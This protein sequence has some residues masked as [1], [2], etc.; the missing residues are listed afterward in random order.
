MAAMHPLVAVLRDA[1]ADQPLRRLPSGIASIARRHR[2]AGTLYHIDRTRGDLLREN[3]REAC[4]AA[5]ADAVG[6]HLLRMEVLC[7]IWPADL[8][9]PLVFKG[10][11]LAENVYADPGARA[12]RDLDLI[13]PPGVFEKA[14][15]ALRPHASEVRWPRYERFADDRPYAIGL[16]IDGVLLEIHAHPMPPHRGGPHGAALW[17]RSMRWALD[18]AALRRPAPVD[19]FVLWLCNQAKGAFYGDLGDLLDGA[20]ILRQL[21]ASPVALTRIATAHGLGRAWGLARRRLA[22]I[23]PAVGGS[24]SVLD[25]LL[26]PVGADPIEPPALRFQAMKWA[27]I[28]PAGRWPALKRGIYSQ[29]SGTNTMSPG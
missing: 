5:W 2:V 7:R 15:A 8:P 4:R 13:V 20:M 1:L 18:G 27:L 12:A 16:V 28:P 29:L 10:A 26:P 17:A 23:W 6:A 25:R 24:R 19:R 14:A 11:D 3:D 22:P 9:A 21:K